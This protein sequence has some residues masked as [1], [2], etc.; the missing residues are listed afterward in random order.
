MYTLQ[1]KTRPTWHTRFPR[2]SMYT[3]CTLPAG[4]LCTWQPFA[5][6]QQRWM[7]PTAPEKK[8]SRHNPQPGWV[9]HWSTTQFLSQHSHW[10]SNK[11]QTSVD[12]RLLGLPS[13]YHRHAIGTFNTCSRIPTPRFLTDTGRGYRIENLRITTAL[14]PPFPSEGS[15]G[16]PN[17]LAQ[18]QIIHNT[19]TNLIG[20]GNKP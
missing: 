17:G 5:S 10:S 8:G 15:T 14:S 11:S 4:G 19:F 1:G 9:I 7:D 16:P 13:P 3:Q 2:Q 20:N 6:H 12:S 18:S